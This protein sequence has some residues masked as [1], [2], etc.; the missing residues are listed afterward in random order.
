MLVD[1]SAD[2]SF[3]KALNLVLGALRSGD[4]YTQSVIVLLEEF[5][6]FAHHHNQT[7]LYNLFDLSQSGFV[8]MMV[9]GVTSRLVCI[10][11][12]VYINVCHVMVT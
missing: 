9:V 4:K 8:P 11:C 1:T 2:L 7:L 6:L 12:R 5:D 10:L 3:H